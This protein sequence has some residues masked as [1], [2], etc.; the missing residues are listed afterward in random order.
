MKVGRFMFGKDFYLYGIIA[1]SLINGFFNR[2]PKYQ[3]FMYE[4]LGKLRYL[5]L[6]LFSLAALGIFVYVQL[7]VDIP[8]LIV[9]L[10]LIWYFDIKKYRAFTAMQVK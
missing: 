2:N 4:K 3:A 8:L 9:V 6:A 5:V 7:L 1:I 10:A